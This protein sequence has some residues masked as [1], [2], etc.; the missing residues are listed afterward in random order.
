MVYVVVQFVEN[1]L[2]YPHVVGSSVG[3]PALW[4]LLAVIIGGKLFGLLGIVFFIPLTAVLYA[5]LRENVT[6]RLRKRQLNIE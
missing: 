3:L 2:I 5:L 1:Q 6:E 4:T